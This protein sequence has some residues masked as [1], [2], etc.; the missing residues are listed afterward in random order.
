MKKK[1]IKNRIPKNLNWE[2][3]VKLNPDLKKHISSEKDAIFHFT[4]HGYKELRRYEV[5]L[6]TDF[7]WKAYVYLNN[8][9][10]K[11]NLT[12]EQCIN[13]Y[14]LHGYFENREYKI[15]LP[16]DFNWINYLEIN[17]DL[18]KLLID[19]KSSINHYLSVGIFEK[20]KYNMNQIVVPEKDLFDFPS[21]Y[22]NENHIKNCSERFDNI[23]IY[24][25]NV[26]YDQ[27]PDN[28]LLRTKKYKGVDENFLK[29]K[30]DN[31]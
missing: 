20:R 7:N 18:N 19:E 9:L 28:Y 29:Y 24:N 23:F 6:P 3:Y 8:D 13:H 2:I 12:K 11:K 21:Y 15:E 27:M 16:S 10:K 22:I 17:Y 26:L 1:E 14:L 30:I 5:K 4:S 31:K 25:K